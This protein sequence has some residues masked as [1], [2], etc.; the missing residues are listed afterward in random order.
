ML[1]A[2]TVIAPSPEALQ[3]RSVG[4]VPVI[5]RSSIVTAT[6]AL[7]VQPPAVVPVIVYIVLTVGD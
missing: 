3:L 6:V 1:V 7:A 4:V 2:V 5:A